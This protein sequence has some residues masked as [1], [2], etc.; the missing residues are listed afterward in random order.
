MTTTEY[1]SLCSEHAFPRIDRDPLIAAKELHLINLAREHGDAFK[2]LFNAHYIHAWGVPFFKDMKPRYVLDEHLPPSPELAPALGSFYQKVQDKPWHP[3][4][5]FPV[6]T[7]AN[8]QPKNTDTMNIQVNLT[9]DPQILSVLNRIADNLG[10]RHTPGT[11]RPVTTLP[12][13]ASTEEAPVPEAPKKRKSA[14]PAPKV[15]EPEP[16]PEVNV[17]TG[18]ELAERIS[19]LK[20]TQYTKQLRAYLDNDLGLAG[21]KLNEVTDAEALKK[22]DQKITELLKAAAEDDV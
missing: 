9:A 18:A 8:E 21:T 5:K 6:A 4:F 15:V 14:T 12:E 19:P 2:T 22:I 10:V 11:E 16:E 3:F 1:N 20:G 13:P 7:T 17:P